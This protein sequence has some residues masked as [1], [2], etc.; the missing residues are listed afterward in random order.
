MRKSHFLIGLLLLLLI[1]MIAIAQDDIV[2]LMFT[3]GGSK[4]GIKD[5][6]TSVANVSVELDGKEYLIKVPVTISID[7]IVPLTSSLVTVESTAKVG[8]LAVEITAT[9]EYTGAIELVVPGLFGD[10]EVEYEPTIEGNKVVAVEFN[11]TN[12]GD[13]KTDLSFYSVQGVDD[14]GRLFDEKDLS[15]ESINPG[16]TGRCVIV[17]DIDSDIDIVALD[18]EIM[19]RRQ[20]P[21]PR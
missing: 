11:T 20:I 10:T 2:E 13:E 18:L 7:S 19:D 16:E 1:P 6:I 21:I 4:V 12:I 8:D 9:S 15:C 5:T 17:F 14:T 3:D